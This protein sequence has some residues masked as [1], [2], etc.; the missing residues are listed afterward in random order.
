MQLIKPYFKETLC[1]Y[2]FKNAP[3]PNVDFA[4]SL[5][6]LFLNTGGLI[7]KNKMAVQ[8]IQNKTT[9]QKV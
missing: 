9:F 6:N 7:Q 4:A 5:H 8:T 1:I 3:T 2:T